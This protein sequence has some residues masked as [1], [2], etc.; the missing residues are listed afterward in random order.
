MTDVDGL[1]QQLRALERLM[2]TSMGVGQ[3]RHWLVIRPD[4]CTWHRHLTPR[5]A[6]R[7]G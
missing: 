4:V 6:R 5:L 2:A 3:H 7:H 1:G